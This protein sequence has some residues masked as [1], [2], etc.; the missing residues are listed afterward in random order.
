[1]TFSTAAISR[2]SE[3]H[4]RKAQ[5]NRYM[6]SQHSAPSCLRAKGSL[7]LLGSLPNV[8]FKYEP[9]PKIERFREHV[10]GRAIIST[11]HEIGAP[12]SIF[13][14]ANHHFNLGVRKGVYFG[15]LRSCCGVS[16]QI[17]RSTFFPDLSLQIAEG[18]NTQCPSLVCRHVL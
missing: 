6:T 10:I 13:F 12:S 15:M 7:A 16:A 1:M 8:I 11:V 17:E 9:C 18:A 2:C 14:A 5:S 3:P 4:S